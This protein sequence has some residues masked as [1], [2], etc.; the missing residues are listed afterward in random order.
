MPLLQL[1]DLCRPHLERLGNCDDAVERFLGVIA[2]VRVRRQIRARLLYQRRKNRCRWLRPSALAQLR[3]PPIS[4]LLRH[5]AARILL[6]A[7]AVLL[8]AI[9]L[10]LAVAFVDGDIAVSNTGLETW[11]KNAIKALWM[12]FL[13]RRLW[14]PRSSSWRRFA[15]RCSRRL[16]YWLASSRC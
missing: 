5:R 8:T 16:R 1:A 14:L 4:N 6:L 3:K 12:G 7:A 15:R 2:L 9:G 11:L 13:I 10:V